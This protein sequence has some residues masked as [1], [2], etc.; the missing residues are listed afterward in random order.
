MT[1]NLH[2]SEEIEYL[3]KQDADKLNVPKSRIARGII[4][5]YYRKHLFYKD[6]DGKMRDTIPWYM[7]DAGIKTPI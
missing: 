7:L 2:L 6:V 4:N 3:L 5:Q 1:V